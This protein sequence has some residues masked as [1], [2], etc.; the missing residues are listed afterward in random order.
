MDEP[1]IGGAPLVTLTAP[2]LDGAG[3]RF[4]SAQVV[5]GRAMMLLQ[6]VADLPGRGEVDLI[7][8][9]ALHE[10]ARRLTGD[11]FGNEAFAFGGAVLAPFANRIR[12]REGDGV[13]E[14]SIGGKAVRLPANWGGKA[15]DAE[16]Y[17]MHGLILDRAADVLTFG[18]D[19]A[20]G[21][22]SP[23][24]AGP[25]PGRLE[26]A[27]EWRLEARRLTLRV[28]A[29]NRGDEPAPVGVGWHPYFA[30][31]SGERGPARLKVPAKS[32]ALVGNYD[33]VLPTGAVEPVA[34]TAYDFRADRPLGEIYLDDCFVDLERDDGEVAVDITDPAARLI[35]RVSTAS[36]NVRAVQVYAPPEQAFVVVE[37][38]FNLANPFGAEW[39]GRDTGMV[40]L[41]PGETTTYEVSVQL[42]S[43]ED[44]DG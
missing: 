10:A 2:P 28:V 27:I 42:L 7:A 34:G 39:D 16:R 6:A 14:T 8:S 21:R 44:A 11:P 19:H 37:P 23:D 38:Q 41:K 3:P 43:L 32:R 36:P 20:S 12:G 24:D 29:G 26:Y 1:S 13:I 35:I 31:P 5:P 22:L 15:S 33:E 4:V 30:L 9:P 40:L 17:A 18:P 25:W